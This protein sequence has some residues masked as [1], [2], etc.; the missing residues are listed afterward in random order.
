MTNYVILFANIPNTVN[1]NTL[2]GIRN[3]NYLPVCIPLRAK[4]ELGGGT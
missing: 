4:Q 1:H 2:I 3:S